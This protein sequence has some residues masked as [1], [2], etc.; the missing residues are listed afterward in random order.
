MLA[1]LHL[2]CRWA[3]KAGYYTLCIL[4][5]KVLNVEQV[6][7]WAL[8]GNQQIGAYLAENRIRETFLY[9]DVL[10]ERPTSRT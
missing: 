9:N 7:S 1:F 6:L 8:D 4:R 5:Q 10:A 2:E 3:I